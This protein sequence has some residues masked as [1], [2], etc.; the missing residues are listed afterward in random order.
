MEVVARNNC[1]PFT[2]EDGSEIRELLAHRSSSIRNQ[3]LA[4]ATLRV[5]QS[6][7]ARY[8]P[9]AEEID[10]ILRGEGRMKFGG[11]ERR[12]GPG[13]VVFTE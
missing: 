1:Q 12:V 8:H 2:N 3:S 10:Y 7:R 11:E 5:G 13:D 9:T 6:T 4:E